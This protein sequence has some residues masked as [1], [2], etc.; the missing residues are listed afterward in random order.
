MAHAPLL[1]RSG[2]SD[3]HPRIVS[4]QGLRRLRK[5]LP[6]RYLEVCL[7]AVGL[8]TVG[9]VVFEGHTTY[10]GEVPALLYAPL[11]FLLWAA[12]RF[13]PGG[14]ST[15]LLVT[16]L[17]AIWG[18]AH[19][20]GPFAALSPT[21]NVFAS[22]MFLVVM[23]VPLMFLAAAIHERGETERALRL[24][25]ELL[26]R[27]E[28][29]SLVMVTHVGLD[30]RWLKVPATLCELLG[31]TEEEL[32]AGHFKDVTHP[33]DFMA[34]WSQCLR[35]ISGEIRS[36][37]LEK[38]YV[39][40]DGHVIWAYLNCSAVT[41]DD[42]KVVYFLTYIKDIS[43]RKRME[44]AL[45]ESEER[46]RAIVEGQT[47]LV[48][49][50]L[51]DTTL[52]FV[53]EA[54]CR[55]FG[56]SQGELI[57]Q[58]FLKLLPEEA[59]D[60]A[61]DH[62]R[63]LCENP[64]VEHDEHP[65]VACDGERRWQQWV[66][67]VILDG[68][69]RIVELQAVGRDITDRKRAEEALRFSEDKFAKAFQSS[70]G[71]FAI[72]RQ[73]D[74]K[75]LEVNERWEELAGYTRQEALGRTTLELQLYENPEDRKRLLAL[76]QD[77]GWVRNF[78]LNLRRKSGE[79]RVASFSAETVK[80][81]GEACLMVILQDI[82]ERKQ[83]EQLLSQ[84]Q[85][86]YTLA[87]TAGRVGLWDWNLETN[88]IYVDAHLK[89]LLGYRDDEIGNH[90]DEWSR[91][92]HPE[93]LPAMMSA[94]VAHIEGRCPSFEMEHRMVRKDGTV[95]W[96]LGRGTLILGQDGERRMVGTDTDIS[97]RKLA[98]EA[99]RRSEEALRESHARIEDL[100]GRLIVAQEQE[101]KHIARELHDDL[102]QQV[103]ALSIG[104][105][106]LERQIPEPDE[107]IRNQIIKLEERISCLLERIRQLSHKLHS[108]ILEHVDLPT[109]LR[110][111]CSEFSEQDK[112]AVALDIRDGSE[113]VSAEV[114]LCVYRIAQEALRNV[115]RHSGAKRAELKLAIGGEAL[116]LHVADRGM[117][118]DPEQ[119]KEH[120]GLGLIS[121]EERVKLLH[122]NFQVNTRLGSGTELRV[123]IPLKGT[124]HLEASHEKSKSAAG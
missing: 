71:A 41:D 54:Y 95:G 77:Q 13:G 112:I 114:A 99:A 39:H 84:S 111:Y 76:I 113:T 4:A 2:G 25:D 6:S 124:S 51:P 94:A 50:Y 108:S 31:Y 106:K 56:K 96:F 89:A 70:P 46:Y 110:H 28:A 109:A 3:D 60:A 104:L 64:R 67:H 23:C 72:A 62:V 35:L 58:S 118:F 117:G 75:H 57:G 87:T 26:S 86:R 42:G 91:Q 38:R 8:V 45:R 119:L 80:I 49:R 120:R 81:G 74:G 107:S 52:T 27:T 65:V 32:L 37:D 115:A 66:Y 24:S 22:Q 92:I 105:G 53:N 63:S 85:R 29:F 44:E 83:T 9:A 10:W 18:G 61:R 15:S 16:A 19:D 116:E 69:G 93:D 101:R 21:E 78:E 103:A 14:L 11:P 82:T 121:M 123:Q 17:L 90:I 97:D 12:V 36:F 33:N 47:D 48:C 55:Y 40:K 43:R 1:Q 88:E 34:D 100:A 68:M 5:E 20:R 102:S 98:E 59:R 122:G 7:L 73:S 30:G 79:I